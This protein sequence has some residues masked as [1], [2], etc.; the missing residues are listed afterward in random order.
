MIYLDSCALVKLV[1]AEPETP[2]LQ[3]YLDGRQSETVSCELALTE[4]LR[5]ARRSC[6][7]QQRRLRVEQAVL[8]A[9][10]NAAAALLDGIDLIVVNTSA[11]IEASAFASDPGVG[12][13]DA[14]HLASARRIGSALTA[15]IT[16]DKAL[17]RAASDCGLPLSQ[18]A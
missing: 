10:L 12:S 8:T 11:F 16:Y 4:V 13:L 15:F 14:I 7:D 5:S 9:R 17:A 6:Y 1:I 3:R 2:A 18:P